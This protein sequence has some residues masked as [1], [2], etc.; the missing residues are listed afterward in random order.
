MWM[1][2]P[3]A[4]Q[5]TWLP[6]L[7]L[8]QMAHL[9]AYWA[10][11]K[12]NRRKELWTS[13]FFYAKKCRDKLLPIPYKNAAINTFWLV[14]T[15][16]TATKYQCQ[17]VEKITPKKLSGYRP[18]FSL[19]NSIIISPATCALFNRGLNRTFAIKTAS[20]FTKIVCAKLR[21]SPIC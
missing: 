18:P 13:N 17:A 20:V 6:C 21:L 10:N 8:M 12:N 15:N 2:V 16:E 7:L 4:K 1:R 14:K 9:T 5:A 19:S 11:G 3:V